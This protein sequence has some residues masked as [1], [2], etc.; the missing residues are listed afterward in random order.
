[1]ESSPSGIPPKQL[2]RLLGVSCKT[3]VGL[4]KLFRGREVKRTELFK[5]Y[6]G[7]NDPAEWKH[8]EAVRTQEKQALRGTPE[9]GRE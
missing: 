7:Y 9:I 5:M 6:I 8:V 3:A 4:I 1:M 2:E